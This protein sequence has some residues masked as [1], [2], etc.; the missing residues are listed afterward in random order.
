MAEPATY[1][2]KHRISVAEVMYV[3]RHEGKTKIH[4]TNGTEAA[5]LLPIHELRDFLPTAEFLNIAKGVLVRRS[6][7]AHIADNGLY[8]MTDSKTFQGRRRNLSAHKRL[9]RE[10]QLEHSANQ[11]ALAAMGLFEKCS[12]LNDMPLAY[13]VIEL[14]FDEN[15]HGVDFIFRYCN[16]QMAVVE[17][18]PVSQML[19]R[20]FYEV[21]KN[22]NKKWLVA[23]A[24]VALNGTKRILNDFSPEIGKQLTIYCY[25]PEPGFC[26]CILI[27]QKDAVADQTGFAIENKL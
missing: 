11:A 12:I 25:Q 3:Y 18:L 10:L 6:Q 8:T 7:I 5:T 14:V 22:G 27:P 26:A 9:R 13:C 20:S 2:K 4:L 23:Y 15:G 16:A 1:F 21:F 17:G 24:D 19:N